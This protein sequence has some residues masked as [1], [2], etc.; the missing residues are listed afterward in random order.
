MGT[1][2]TGAISIGDLTSIIGREIPNSMSE[3]YS[4][5]GWISF[6]MPNS[7]I[8]SSG[9][10]SLSDFQG[11]TFGLYWQDNGEYFTG[12][13]KVSSSFSFPIYAGTRANANSTYAFNWVADEWINKGG[14]MQVSGTGT[15]GTASGVAPSDYFGGTNI[16]WYFGIQITTDGVT[17]D[18]VCRMDTYAG[19]GL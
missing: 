14:S 5:N 13:S 10:I 18:Y 15:T 4:S 3:Y 2:P 7:D 6:G 17:T 9:P 1:L 11:K 16:V 12:L 8:P 19:S